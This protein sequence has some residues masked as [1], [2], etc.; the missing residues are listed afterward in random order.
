MASLRGFTG[1][2][3]LLCMCTSPLRTGS[4]KKLLW[5]L[6]DLRC[7]VKLDLDPS[8]AEFI[9]R[10]Y[11]LLPGEFFA[12]HSSFPSLP[13][14]ATHY[15]PCLA[16]PVPRPDQVEFVSVWNMTL[17]AAPSSPVPTMSSPNTGT[18]VLTF[19]VIMATFLL[20]V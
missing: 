15:S 16:S 2:S 13:S 4:R 12:L 7:T 19:R 8:L 3:C 18:F 17:I 20:T 9:F 1:F 5:M 14:E 10:H 11:L 6:L